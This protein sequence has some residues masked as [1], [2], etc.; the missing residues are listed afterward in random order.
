MIALTLPAFN[1]SFAEDLPSRLKFTGTHSGL[2][3]S[4]EV[5][6]KSTSDP[7][8]AAVKIYDWKAHFFPKKWEHWL[9]ILSFQSSPAELGLPQFFPRKKI[10]S[11]GS[12]RV[13][14]AEMLAPDL[15]LYPM[16]IQKTEPGRIEIPIHIGSFLSQKFSQIT[17]VLTSPPTLKIKTNKGL[18][19]TAKTSS[20]A[21]DN[22]GKFLSAL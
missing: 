16:T 5:D 20:I 13:V 11:P 12:H 4:L 2:T 8:I 10:T 19:S 22:C 14:G 7:E 21:V 1:S 17:I 9:G 6:L 18:N 3:F 15:N